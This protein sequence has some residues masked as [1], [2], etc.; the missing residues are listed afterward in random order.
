MTQA[1]LVQLLLTGSELCI[2][3]V[4]EWGSRDFLSDILMV[5]SVSI[6]TEVLDGIGILKTP[7]PFLVCCNFFYCQFSCHAFERNE[8]V[9]PFDVVC[10]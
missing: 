8:T 6:L 5:Y 7:I 9:R 10:C 3:L 4:A 1:N 2:L